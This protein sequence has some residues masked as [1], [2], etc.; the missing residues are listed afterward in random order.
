MVSARGAAAVPWGALR[1]QRLGNLIGRDFKARS[2]EE[3][4]VVFGSAAAYHYSEVCGIDERPVRAHRIRKSIGAE[5]T[6]ADD[7]AEFD[8]LAERL[9]PMID[10]VWRASEAKGTSGRTVTLKRKFSD[11]VQITRAR[12]LDRPVPDRAT[13][14]GISLALLR[15][16]YPLRRSVRLIGVSLSALQGVAEEEPQQLGLAI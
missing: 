1:S 14:A 12:S 16:A 3:L 13:L 10:K 4:Q 5:T 7:T 15:D 8:V 9:A 6:D 2:L 11:F